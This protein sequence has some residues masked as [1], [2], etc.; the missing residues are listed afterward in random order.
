MEA[1]I[2]IL[3]EQIPGTLLLCQSALCESWVKNAEEL[4]CSQRSRKTQLHVTA[5]SRLLCQRCC[6][7][8]HVKQMLFCSCPAPKA[9]F[10]RTN[11][12][13]AAAVGTYSPIEHI[14]D[15]TLLSSIFHTFENPKREEVFNPKVTSFILIPC[16]SCNIGIWIYWFVAALLCKLQFIQGL[17][18]ASSSRQDTSRPNVG[19]RFCIHTVHRFP[20][21]PCR[22]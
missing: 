16:P 8:R 14:I 10:Q 19:T 17:F 18:L 9:A 13:T 2:W 15:H 11:C 1:W 5:N 12:L 7:A 4:I 3:K 20:P 6:F 22:R 21:K